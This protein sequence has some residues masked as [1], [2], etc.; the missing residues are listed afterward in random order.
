LVLCSSRDVT[1]AVKV[2]NW[3]EGARLPTAAD[4]P[5]LR[6]LLPPFH[7][8][9]AVAGSDCDGFIRHCGKQAGEEVYNAVMDALE[10]HG[11]RLLTVLGNRRGELFVY[12]RFSKLYS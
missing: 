11:I 5:Q 9:E 3:S 7:H 2:A 8:W 10:K 6:A 1:H 4:V 12:C